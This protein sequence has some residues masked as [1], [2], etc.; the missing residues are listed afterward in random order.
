LA[1]DQEGWD[2]FALQLRNGVDLMFYHLRKKDGLADSYSGGVWVPWDGTPIPLAH[3]DVE[4]QTLAYWTS[5]RGGR[6]PA[7]WQLIVPQRDCRFAITPILA[8]QE[9]DTAVRYWEGAVDVTGVCA[10]KRVGGWGY[11]EL[12]GYAEAL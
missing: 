5:S 3:Q 7:G 4:I 12:T 11:V 9:L 10:D 6:Y 2:W 1:E 8:D